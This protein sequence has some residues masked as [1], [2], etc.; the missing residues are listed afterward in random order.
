M[1]RAFEEDSPHGDI[2]SEHVIPAHFTGEADLVAREDGVLSGI[3][4]FAAA[5]SFID[6]QV[7]VEQYAADGHHFQAGERL[8]KVSGSMRA[9]LRSE[10]IALNF[11]QHMSGIATATASFVHEV[12]GKLI[13]IKDTRKTLPGLRAVQRYAVVC[14]GGVNHRD[15]LSDAV[16]MKDNHLA[17]LRAA[18]IP[19]ARAIEE[20]RSIRVDG[21][22]VSVEVE[23]DDLGQIDEVIE[24]K[25][26]VI[27]LDNFSPEDTVRAVEHIR[28]INQHQTEIEASGNMTLEK[29][30]SIAD[31][32]IDTISI[33]SLTHSVIG[34]D[35]GLDWAQ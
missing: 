23:V 29:V 34:V 7:K 25:P 24:G 14:G 35:L 3:D 10:R 12:Q 8:A 30:R 21:K 27:M 15:G 19:I 20:A 2:T 18:G 31:S 28:R 13:A 11:V 32:G 33:G 22:P 4:I 26:D 5:F 6:T 16:M 9:I 17:A 1:R